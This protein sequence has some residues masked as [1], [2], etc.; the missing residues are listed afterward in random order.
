MCQLGDLVEQ[1]VELFGGVVGEQETQ[2]GRFL[3]KEP[4]FT[5]ACGNCGFDAMLDVAPVASAYAYSNNEPVTTVDL[6]GRQHT[7]TQ[8]DRARGT[9]R[10]QFDTST[11]EARVSCHSEQACIDR[12]T[13]TACDTSLHATEQE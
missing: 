6:D 1:L 2:I 8:Y 13:R 7:R 12:A 3:T 4:L 10:Y 11:L 9:T 5:D